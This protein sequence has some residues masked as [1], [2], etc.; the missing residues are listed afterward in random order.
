MNDEND[1]KNPLLTEH[2]LTE[3]QTAFKEESTNVTE[4]LMKTEA[5]EEIP[6]APVDN[7]DAT[8]LT[9][10]EEKRKQEER[11]R[12][13][14]NRICL[15]RLHKE[16]TFVIIFHK[17]KIKRCLIAVQLRLFRLAKDALLKSY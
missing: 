6:Q 16:L 9:E 3:D 7:E 11:G 8:P 5:V 12:S 13:K 4:P 1:K 17:L 15:L 14:K 2:P 10:E